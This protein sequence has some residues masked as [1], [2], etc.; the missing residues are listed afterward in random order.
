[1]P[2]VNG[3]FVLAATAFTLVI[4]RAK[5]DSLPADVRALID[6][7]TGVEG[8]RRVGGLYDAAEAEG[9]EYIAKSGAEIIKPTAEEFVVFRDALKSTQEETL[10]G[11]EIK[12]LKAR[13]FHA[14]IRHL[15]GDVKA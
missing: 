10:V 2:F 6:E 12:G 13:A 15:V 9:R 5:Y 11:L 14:R 4:N 7:T 1:M 8:A 3:T